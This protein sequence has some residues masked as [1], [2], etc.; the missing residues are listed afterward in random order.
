MALVLFPDCY[1]VRILTTFLFVCFTFSQTH[2]NSKQWTGT[3]EIH[4]SKYMIKTRM[5][6]NLWCIPL[7]P[8]LGRQRQEFLYTQGCIDKPCL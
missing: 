7:I 2:S 5:I 4:F 6:R 1:D 3:S 8:A